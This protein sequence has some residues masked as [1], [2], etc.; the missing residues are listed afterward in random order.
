MNENEKTT[1]KI[2]EFSR[3]GRVTVRTLRHYEQIGLLEPE[4]VDRWTGYRYYSAGQLQKLLTIVQ[5][6]DL[7]F[8][9]SEIAELYAGGTHYPDITSIEGKIRDCEHELA[10]LRTRRDRLQSLLNAQKKKSKMEKFYVDTLP[11]VIV[12]CSRFTIGTYD[13]LGPHLVS[14]VAPEMARLGCQCPEPG[15]CFTVETAAEY[16]P[17][18]IEVEYC[19]QVLSAGTD[20][21]IV[22]F[23]TL[24]E[25]PQAICMKVYGPYDRLYQS[26]VELFAYI[27]REG[28]I[29]DGHPRAVYVDGIWNEEDPAKWLTIIQT[30]VRRQ[31]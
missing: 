3:L 29:L 27:A 6:R 1:Y 21:P 24:P 2:G 9:L 7:G 14:V 20:S 10:R 11:S 22:Q 8:T 19:E 17:R 5:L 4:V 15:Y 30:P 28:Y 23:K 13:D 16:R 31:D 18:D 12:A 25:V 26:Y